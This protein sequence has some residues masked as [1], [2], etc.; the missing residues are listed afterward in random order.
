MNRAFRANGLVLLA[1]CVVLAGCSTSKK[2]PN[3]VGQPQTEASSAIIGAGLAVG[4]ITQDYSATVAAGFVISQT[5]PAGTSV[6]SGTAVDLVVSQGSPPAVVPDVAG[7]TQVAAAMA[8]VGADLVVGTVTQ[9]YSPTVASGLVISQTPV[10]GTSVVHRTSVDLV[11]SRGP[12]PQTVTVPNVAGM[13]QGAA[14]SAIAG[15]GLSVGTVTQA[16]SATVAAGSI[17]SQTPAAGT[18]VSP[19]AAVNLVVSQG[20]QPILVAVPNVA[21]MT[22]AAASSVIVGAN[23]VVGTVTQGYSATVPSGS[24]VSQTPAAGTSV[25]PGAAIN[26]VVSQGPQPVVVPDVV[27]MTQVEAGTTLANALLA[28]G[29]VT[30]LYSTT[31]PSGEVM[32]QNPAAGTSVAAGTPV[33]LSV[34]KGPE[35]VAV[36]NV[37]G[38]TQAAAGTA[39]SN[40]LLSLGAVTRLYSSTVPTGNVVQQNPTA[41]TSVA[42]GTAV[43][44]GVSKGPQKMIAKILNVMEIGRAHV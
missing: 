21:G 30:R 40:A 26:L 4:T 18:S 44:L 39:L 43:D 14:A 28:L 3:V 10:A 7:L 41:G 19:G 31:V 2:V 6:K 34:S 29:S 35:F 42:P 20:P 11:L 1:L 9:A 32:G 27:G 25:A 16:Y 36:P 24:V 33:D 8:I 5:P 37:V 15:V 23:L 38:L 22:Q 12:E 17:I 13:T